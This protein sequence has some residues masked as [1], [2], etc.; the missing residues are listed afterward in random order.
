MR[1]YFKSRLSMCGTV[2]QC[3]TDSVE[4][5]SFLMD[6]PRPLLIYFRSFQTNITILTTN[7]FEKMLWPSSI[8]RRDSNPRPSELQVSSHDHYTRAPAHRREILQLYLSLWN[9]AELFGQA[10]GQEVFGF[11]W[12]ATFKIPN[13]EKSFRTKNR[14]LGHKQILM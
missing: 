6:N 7:I 8:W 14:S 11:V 3:N 2:L 1:P 5:S 12:P 10:W 9:H 13:Q 4:K